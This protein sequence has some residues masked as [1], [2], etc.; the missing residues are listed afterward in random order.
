MPRSA[1]SPSGARVTAC[2]LLCVL[3]PAARLSAQGPT[4]AAIAGR[5]TDA[6]GRGLP[7]VEVLVTNRATGTPMRSFSR[8]EG[9]YVVAGLEVGG[10]YAVTARRIGSRSKTKTGFYLSLGQQLQVDIEL[11]QQPVTLVGVETRATQHRL[12]SRA[13]QGAET[14]ISDSVIHRMPVLNRDLYD[15]VRLVPQTSTW[16]ASSASG[17]GPRVNSIRIDG[18]SDQVVS[19]NLAAGALYGGKVIPLDAVQEYQVLLSPY[20]VRHG[21]FA[22]ASINVVTRSGTNERRGSVFGY[23]TNERLGPNVPLIRRA[24]YDKAQF[25]FSLGGPIVRDRLH[26]FIASELQSRVIPATGPYFE[27]DLPNSM[28]PVRPPDIDRFQRLL[29]AHGLDGGSAGAVSN[30]N[31]SSSVFLRLDAP[32]VPW[33]S[34]VTLRG[35]YGYGD[36]SIFARPTMLA[37][38]NCPSSECFPLSSLRHSRWVDK[39][40]AAVQLLTNF[41]SGAYNEALLGYTGTLAGF[42]PTVKQPLVL[43]TVPGTRGGSAVLQAGTHEIATGQRNTNWTAELSD[44][45]AISAG[46]HRIML[47]VSAQLFELHAF[48][49]RGAYG[50]WEFASLDSLQ[51]ATASRYRVT[52][53]TGSVTV[54]SGTHHAL[55][56]ADEW[57]VSPRLSVTF[58]L[59]AD[60]PLL[61]AHPPYVSAVDSVFHLRTDHVPSGTLQWSPRLGFNYDL[62]RAGGAPAQLRGGI[63]AFTGRP[64]LFWLFG[65]FSAYGLAV[66]TLQC[67]SLLTDAGAP[68][69]FSSDY[70][71]PPLACAGGETFGESSMGEIDVIDRRLRLPQVVRASLAVD[72]GLPLGWV[73]TIEG[74]YTR[75]MRSVFFSGIN[76]GEPLATDRNDRLLYGSFSATGVARPR[77]VASQLGDVISISNQSRDYA[78]DVTGELRHEGQWANVQASLSYG[79]ARDVQ[80]PRPLSALL[81][82][83][84]R[85]SRPVAGRLDDLRL[86][87]SDFDQPVRARLSGTIHSPWQTLRTDLSFVYVGGSGFPYTYV[88]GGTQGRGDLNAD[89]AIGNDPIYIPRT[90]FDTAEIRFAGSPAEVAMQQAAFE[91]FIDG[92]ACLRRQRGQIMSRNSCRSPWMHLLNLALRQALPAPRS[93]RVALEVQVFNVLNLVNRHWGQVQLPGGTPPTTT[94]QV[95][96][97]SQVAQTAGALSVPVYRFDTM[98]RRYS[99]DNTDSYYQ[100]QFAARYS[101]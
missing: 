85:F 76:L 63:G 48:Q 9:R 22:G 83:N 82:D 61:S 43:V 52:R 58:G 100:I 38:T 71:D 91:R 87:A 69:V 8:A 89:G 64:P 13:H 25:G 101:F 60:V 35:T 47:G 77:R 65:G 46:P 14:L 97:L 37:P 94:S 74:V 15:L 26:Y 56:L 31:P 30:E 41:A 53:D 62:A 17:A 18:I 84:W 29:S 11:E 23:A 73:A 7:G 12:F 45:F 2:A 98:T 33:N 1:F 19:S 27:P 86:G 90:S 24:R 96:L 95:P 81:I 80:S 3:G 57:S 55:Y 67:G 5:V 39:R 49:L 28:L 51:A 54:A 72:R 10:P 36:S 34:R 70:W 42:R 20:D 50:V 40:S 93:Q 44:N 6:D 88:A 79:R 32:I 66:R 4:T 68:P 21:G 59:R 92:A 16:F 99:F 78:Y 75:S